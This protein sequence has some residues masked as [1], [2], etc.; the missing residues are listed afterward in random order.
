MRRLTDEELT[1]IV[2]TDHNL[3]NKLNY[4]ARDPMGHRTRFSD[5]SIYDEVCRYCGATDAGR[6]LLS[7][8]PATDERKDEV[9]SSQAA[10]LGVS[11]FYLAATTALTTTEAVNSGYLVDVDAARRHR[12]ELV[13]T[14]DEVW[15]EVEW[16]GTTSRERAKELTDEMRLKMI[17]EAM[18]TG[19]TFY[20]SAATQPGWELAIAVIPRPILLQVT[21]P[22]TSRRRHVGGDQ[23]IRHAEMWLNGVLLRQ[24]DEDAAVSGYIGGDSYTS[25]VEAEFANMELALKVTRTRVR[26]VRPL[27]NAA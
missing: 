9:D 16:D 8:C 18:R 22:P 20:L 25:W 4:L 27:A 7:R 26:N 17:S 5:S 23:T 24:Y 19:S 3:R 1:A 13:S 11:E 6:D 12:E 15:T 14:H 2:G 21:Q 10:E